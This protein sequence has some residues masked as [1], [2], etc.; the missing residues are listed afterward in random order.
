MIENETFKFE[1]K[2]I[3]NWTHAGPNAVETCGNPRQILEMAGKYIHFRSH[4]N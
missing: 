1:N 4:E 3:R 2:I